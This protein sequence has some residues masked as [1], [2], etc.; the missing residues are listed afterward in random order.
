MLLFVIAVAISSLTWF[1][2]FVK[3]LREAGPFAIAERRSPQWIA[4]TLQEPVRA[5]MTHVAFC[6][7]K[8]SIGQH[9]TTLKRYVFQDTLSQNGQLHDSCS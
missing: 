9:M 8:K 3:C 1:I 5:A 7:S 6:A 4:Q 2:F